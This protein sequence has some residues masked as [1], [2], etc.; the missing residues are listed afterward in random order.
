MLVQGVTQVWTFRLLIPKYPEWPIPSVAEEQETLFIT[1]VFLVV[2][3]I[4]RLIQKVH[5]WLG[6]VIVVLVQVDTDC[7][8][9]FLAIPAA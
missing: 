1:F 3:F 9:M 4:L 6:Q 8:I 7:L 5:R 2:A